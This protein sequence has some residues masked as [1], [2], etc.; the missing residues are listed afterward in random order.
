LRLGRSAPHA[1]RVDEDRPGAVLRALLAGRD[2]SLDVAGVGILGSDA[3]GQADVLLVIRRPLGAAPMVRWIVQA[4]SRTRFP[5]SIA[6]VLIAAITARAH[7]W[8]GLHNSA[9][10]GAEWKTAELARKRTGF[11]ML[12]GVGGIADRVSV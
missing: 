12:Q 1:E 6:S 4:G 7:G 8:L 3:V 10:G 11:G 5:P 2:D 9:A